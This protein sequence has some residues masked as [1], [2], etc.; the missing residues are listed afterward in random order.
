MI[1]PDLRIIQGGMGAGVSNYRLA[2][3]V[4]RGGGLGV[5]SGTALD[6]LLV[7]RLQNGDPTGELRDALLHFPHRGIAERIL[8]DYFIPGGRK[9]EDPYRHAP[10]PAFRPDGAGGFVPADGSLLNLIVAAN[11]VEVY[12]AKQGHA[13]TG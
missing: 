11:F 12:L 5:V 8:A 13:K 7:R 10:F 9:P 2:N 1:G 6:T 4:A 3:A